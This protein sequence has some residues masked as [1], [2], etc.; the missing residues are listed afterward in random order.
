MAV[1]KWQ[2]NK[3]GKQVT[4]STPPGQQSCPS[5]GYHVWGKLGR[6]IKQ[7]LDL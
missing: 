4:S 7:I 5:G 3:C 2:C 1:I 6:F